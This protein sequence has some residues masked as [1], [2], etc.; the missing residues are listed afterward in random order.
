MTGQRIT[1]QSNDGT[2]GAYLAAPS[3]GRGPGIVIIQE[4]FGI[5][6]FVRAVADHFAAHGYFALAPDLF[7]RL[8]PGIELTDQTE[9][10]WKKAFS[11]MQAFDIDKGVSD[12][13]TA[14]TH[15]RGV[16]GCT[17]KVGA[18]GYCLGGQLAYLAASRT[19]ADAS[20]GYY[21]VYI[22]N[23]LDEAK[24]IK[25]PLLLHI[26][27]K[28]Q[29]TPADAQK[30]IL[31]ALQGHPQ[32]TIHSYPQMDHAFARPSG[33]HYDKACAEL[34]N[35]RTDTFFRQHLG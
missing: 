6:E 18:V 25:K 1:L 33:E 23:R 35:T 34:A 12:I 13:Q 30:Q 28:D 2:F 7:W 9:E 24:A 14:I 3:L 10:H 16:Q 31:D 29:F 20:V 32:I 26:A 4:I 11:L 8:E 19:D 17:G 5:N 27:E 15:L 22:Q 21:G